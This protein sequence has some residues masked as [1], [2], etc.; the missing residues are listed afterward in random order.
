M[1]KA[2]R[3]AII[4]FDCPLTPVLERYMAEGHLPNFK[5][6]VEGGVWAENCIVPYP[7][8][9]PPNWATIGTGA[10]IETHQ[11][12]DFWVP[13]PGQTPDS[14]HT[15]QAFSSDRVQAEFIWDAAD[16]AGK[17][18]VVLNFPTSWPNHM[19]NGIVIGGAG[20][21][22]VDNMDG[23]RE[24]A[25][26][27]VCTQQMITTG[28]YP[29]AIR[30]QWQEAEGWA[31]LDE[32]GLDALEMPAPLAFP[33]AV[34]QP[35]PTTWW[36]LARKSAGDAYDTITLSPAKDFA[37]A[38]CT[39][40]VGEW[41]SKVS[42]QIA[43][44]DG[45]TRDVVFRCKLV[46]LSEEADDFRMLLTSLSNPAKLCS[47]VSALEKIPSTENLPV[48][49]ACMRDAILGRIDWQTW[50]ECTDI[51]SSWLADAA[52]G[53]LKD[54][55][56]DVFAMHS[57][58]TDFGYHIM[59]TDLDPETSSDPAK[60]VAAEQ[61]QLGMYQVQ[62][63]MLGR[64]LEALPRETLV[65][66]VSDHG[67]VADGPMFDP[68]KALA[69]NGL[70]V[71]TKEEE[72]DNPLLQLR[73]ALGQMQSEVDLTQTKA[74]T[75]GICYVN[76]NLKGRDPEGIVE[77]EDYEKVQLEIVDALLTYVDP[78]TGTR[79]VAL[80]LTKKD[81]RLLRMAGDSV[82]DVVYA[83]YPWFGGQHGNIL[84][85][86]EWGVGSL[87]GLLVFNGPGIKRGHRMERTVG[88]QDIVPTVCH[89][90]DLPVPSTVDGAVIWQ[91]F[92]DPNFKEREVAKLQGGLERMQAALARKTR[93]PWDKHD[94]A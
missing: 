10:L 68:Y 8:I 16:K 6:V 30:G 25:V 9:T 85:T 88:L 73:K 39:V 70:A 18:C 54:G 51:Y 69:P 11:V 41:S 89:A 4:G 35:A 90:C 12:S 13:V 14:A 72:A 60:K 23:R 42:T 44:A 81:A 3:V 31:N 20:L 76:V 1:A 22:P 61:T 32:P 28:Y 74:I 57:H 84:P 64:I 71:V 93:Q 67:A 77:P 78:R 53:L 27:S 40:K 80:A 5:K 33:A 15:I 48:S 83:L 36:V 45:A 17:K 65:V 59:M 58:P 56:W 52:T 21:G 86:A 49:Y 79:P 62:D 7:T 87:R 19:Q 55:D 34:E 63:R 66:L 24:G 43:M 94:C 91:V 47:P 37:Q 2:K 29:G 82:G 92:K 75:R 26:V 38:F 46:E 50:V